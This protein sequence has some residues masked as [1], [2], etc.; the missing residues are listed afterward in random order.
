MDWVSIPDS[1]YEDQ[2]LTWSDRLI[3]MALCYYV[4]H[5]DQHTLSIVDISTVSRISDRNAICNGVKRL[6]K[7]GWIEC[8]RTKGKATSYKVLGRGCLKK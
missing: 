7:A 8:S 2:R 5:K 3:Y 6:E 4:D 1:L